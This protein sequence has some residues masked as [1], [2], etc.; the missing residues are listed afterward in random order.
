MTPAAIARLAGVERAA[1]SNRRRRYP[2]FPKPVGGSPTSPTF[3]LA[4]VEAW[5]KATRKTGQ[6]ATAGQTDTG[7]QRVGEPERSITGMQPSE[8]LDRSMARVVAPRHRRPG[9]AGTER[10]GPR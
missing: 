4:E 5:L 6:L 2:E 9:R 8:L 7:T 1:V 3:D 10:P